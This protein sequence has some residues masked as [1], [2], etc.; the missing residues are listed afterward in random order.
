M[1]LNLKFKWASF[2]EITTVYLDF[3]FNYQHSNASA[4]AV[5]LIKLRRAL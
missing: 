1:K 4:D 5:K 3:K 2:M